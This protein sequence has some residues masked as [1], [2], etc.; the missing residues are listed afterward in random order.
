M[1]RNYYSV[2]WLLAFGLAMVLVSGCSRESRKARYLQ[3][4]GTHLEKGDYDRAEI[5]YLNALRLNPGDRTAI[6]NLGIIAYEQN[7]LPRA[8]VLLRKAQEFDPND[9]EVRLR[10]GLTFLTEG[11]AKQA[12]SEAVFV[13]EKQ[14]T[15]GEAM[16][17][18]VDSSVGTNEL[19]DAQQR[20]EKLK[21]AADRTAGFHLA[22][23][24]IQMRSGNPAA[25]EDSFQRALAADPRSSAAHLAMGNIHLQKKDRTQAEREFKAAADLSPVRSANRIRYA[26]FKAAIGDVPAAR[27][28]LRDMVKQAPDYRPAQLGLAQFALAERKFDD[29]EASLKLL[30][31]RDAQDLQALLLTADLHLARNEPAK[32][33]AVLEEILTRHPDLSHVRYRLAVAAQRNNDVLKAMTSLNQVLAKQPDNL[34]ATL[35]LAELNIRRGNATA[36]IDALTK[37]VRQRPGLW[38]PQMLLAA[39]HRAKGDF[40]EAL[41]IYR[42]VSLAYPTNPEPAYLSGLVWQQR[43]R[44]AEARESFEK[45]FELAPTYIPGLAQLTYLDMAAGRFEAAHERVRKQIEQQPASPDLLCLQAQIHLA[46][47]NLVDA[48]A[49]LN[50]ALKLAPDFPRA[51]FLVARLYVDSGRGPEALAKLQTLVS[52]NPH[53][54]AAWLQIAQIQIA[55][56]NHVAAKEAYEKVLAINP[57]AV[58]VLNNLAWIHCEN[59]KDL[60]RA[61]ELASQASNLALTD[62]HVADT[63]GW[64]LYQSSNYA[65]AQRLLQESAE[66]L[67]QQA[68]VWFHLGMTHYM[69]GEE[70]P[71]RTALQTALRLSPDAAWRDDA[72]ERLETLELSPAKAEAGGLAQLE[73]KL[74]ERPADPVVLVRVA[75]LYEREAA[76]NK[77]AD[78]YDRLLRVTPHNVPALVKAAQI[79]SV[80]L[81]ATNQALALMRRAV[82]LTPGDL[83][84]AYAAGR[85]AYAGSDH[86]WAV[87]LLEECALKQPAVPEVLFDFAM[88]AYSVGRTSDAQAAMR[89]AVE[90]RLPSPQAEQAGRFLQLNAVLDDPAGAESTQV[91]EIIA[92]QPDFPPAMVAGAVTS[93]KKRDFAAARDQYERVLER[94]PLFSPANRQL[95]SIYFDNLGDP[96]KGNTHALQARRAFPRDPQLARILGSVAFQKGEFRDA[97][98]LLSE[99]SREFQTDADLL[100]RLGISQFKLKQSQESKASLT[101][102]LAMAPNSSFA[103]EAQR[104]LTEL[105]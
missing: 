43:G 102:A 32:A 56:S 54:T 103:P 18:L 70:N 89:R 100:F 33:V 11:E 12:R 74:S 5:E 1:F 13:L 22:I 83:Q 45:T 51:Q 28:I 10:L 76:W 77:A 59:L 15:N 2:G 62:P 99:S 35:L 105:R 8:F 94:M 58:S 26:E 6:R 34:E 79:S 14:P 86:K 73:K 49:A 55:A 42:H 95:A 65:S 78:A 68:G 7:R 91:Q 98:R 81:N 44:D 29:C 21:A 25:A 97:A 27:E 85:V 47:T 38:A 75:A 4:A 66:K 41:K 87:E 61:Y 52:R 3:Q 30:L 60:K 37:V 57:K 93:E 24:S 19:Q 63:L 9:I 40:D 96:L 92:R 67:P 84:V 16:L 39:A 50:Q 80:H 104:L 23:G 46:Q 88:A 69:L 17:L 90:A 64:V 82:N 48:E 71:A 53:E 20:L 31:G 36:A 72:R 101:R